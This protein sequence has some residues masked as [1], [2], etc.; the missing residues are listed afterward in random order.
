M[1]IY[2]INLKNPDPRI[3]KKAVEVIK[4]GGILVYPTDTCYGLGVDP[5]N[6]E[7]MKRLL[8]LKGRTT[9]KKISLI[10]SD[11]GML[12]RLCQID[13]KQEEI[14]KKYLPGPFTFI[15]KKKEGGTLG[16]R[17]PDCPVTQLLAQ[18][19]EIPYTATS[20]NL[21]GEKECYSIKCLLSQFKKERLDLILDVGELPKNPPS[22]VV[23]LTKKEAKVLRRGSGDFKG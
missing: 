16:V 19:L 20:A 4:K 22:T 17:I 2:K 1:E 18:E 15:L 10:V 13:Q 5:E 9:S 23:D 8:K 6:K 11:F 14:L 12:K 21:S 3:I 7:A